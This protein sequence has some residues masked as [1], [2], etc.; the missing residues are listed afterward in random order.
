MSGSLRPHGLQHARPP[1]PSPTPR[2]WLNSC[3][4]SQWWH[5]TISS[6]VT[7]FS[8]CPQSFTASGSFLVSQHFLSGG[9]SIGYSASTS[10]LQVNIQDWIS[11]RIDWFDLHAVQRALKGFLQHHNSKASIL[12]HSAF[13]MSSSHV[14]TRL[15]EKP[16]LCRDRPLLAKW[17]LF[18]SFYCLGLS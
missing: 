3:P 7:P 1:C 18:F 6:S 12:W 4:L 17:C 15:L 11:F 14:H 2:V 5:P 13:F 16:Y 9:R 8:F 10:V